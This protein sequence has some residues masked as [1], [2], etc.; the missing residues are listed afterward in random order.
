ME[1]HAGDTYKWYE[2]GAW[3]FVL[4]CFGFCAWVFCLYLHAYPVPREFR[5]KCQI[6][7]K[8]G[9]RWLWTRVWLLGTEFR[10]SVRATGV[11]NQWAIC[12]V[13]C[14]AGLGWALCLSSGQDEEEQ[15]MLLSMSFGPTSLYYVPHATQA[16]LELHKYWG[17]AWITD[18]PASTSLV[19]ES[20]HASLSLALC[21]L[22]MP[23]KHHAMELHPQYSP[24][25]KP[26]RVPNR[27]RMY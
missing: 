27:L 17:W 4:F 23:S 8:W 16:G 25:R 21:H 5:R 12:L 26:Y 14:W 15:T 13:H 6:P 22:C 18:P 11:L 2:I 3:V 19:L 7:W 20:Q 24:N 9:Y 1:L 10:S